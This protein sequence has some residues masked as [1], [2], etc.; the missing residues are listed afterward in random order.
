MACG[1]VGSV[2][3]GSRFLLLLKVD[4]KPGAPAWPALE[5]SPNQRW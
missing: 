2:Y 1:S 3:G 4:G 5:N